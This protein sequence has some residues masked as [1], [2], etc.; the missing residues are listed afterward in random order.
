MWL[1]K[2]IIHFHKIQLLWRNHFHMLDK[3]S[4]IVKKLLAFAFYTLWDNSENKNFYHPDSKIFNFLEVW[5]YNNWNNFLLNLDYL[6]FLNRRQF[7]K[8]FHSMGQWLKQH[9]FAPLMIHFKSL[10]RQNF[11]QVYFPIFTILKC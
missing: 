9:H 10:L 4:G 7:V 11:T 8:Q 1:N 6:H 2:T 3:F 5:I